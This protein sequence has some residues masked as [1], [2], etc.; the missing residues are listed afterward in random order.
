MLKP[1]W[2]KGLWLPYRGVPK[3][4][5]DWAAVFIAKNSQN[6]RT[7]NWDV[8]C[9]GLD[10]FKVWRAVHLRLQIESF[11]LQFVPIPKN[12]LQVDGWGARHKKS[13][14]AVQVT[15]ERWGIYPPEYTTNDPEQS[16]SSCCKQ[17]IVCQA[18]IQ[19]IVSIAPQIVPSTPKNKE[20]SRCHTDARLPKSVLR[21]KDA[22]I[23]IYII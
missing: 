14:F 19:H 21:L 2:P 3:W 1:Q 5:F 6:T 17:L 20:V 11:E 18:L 12:A 9:T 16:L 23:Y 4:P 13:W 15:M 10:S 7:S 8:N 22:Y